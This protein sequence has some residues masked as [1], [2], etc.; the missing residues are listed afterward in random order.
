MFVKRKVGEAVDHLR[1]RSVSTATT[2]LLLDNAMGGF[3][4]ELGRLTVAPFREIPH[5]P[6]PLTTGHRAALLFGTLG[7]EAVVV[8]EGRDCLYEGYFHRELAFPLRVLADLGLKKLL[9]VAWM[10]PLRPEWKG[11]GLV[12][13]T[14]HIDLSGGSPLKGLR[15]PEGLTFPID[16]TVPY[17]SAFQEEARHLGGERGVPLESAVMVMVSGPAGPT[18]A[19][20]RM[21]TGL[22][23]DVLSMTMAAEIVMAR[24]LGIE[25]A[26]F[27]L[28]RPFP[29]ERKSSLAT[30]AWSVGYVEYFRELLRRI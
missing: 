9:L 19:E 16:M 18:G 3:S 7:E 29:G 25:I 17:S 2:G 10:Q 20:A 13:V 5:F 28:L 15:P 26:V 12:L 14:D 8:Q 24:Y 11:G 6:Q 21:F 4:N 1:R 22:G 30:D 23:A 27:G